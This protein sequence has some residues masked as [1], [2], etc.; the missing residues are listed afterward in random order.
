MPLHSY[1]IDH[2]LFFK[3]FIKVID[4]EIFKEILK[5]WGVKTELYQKEIENAW[6]DFFER[7]FK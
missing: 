7:Y 3:S 4:G 2:T 1:S 5:N 6:N